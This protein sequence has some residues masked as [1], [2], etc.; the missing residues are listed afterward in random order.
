M[1]F[2][3]QMLSVIKLGFKMVFQLCAHFITALLNA[4][5]DDR[6]DVL[7]QRAIFMAHSSQTLFH[8]T[9]YGA[10]PPGMKGTHRFVSR[11]HQQDRETIS[12]LYAQGHARHIGD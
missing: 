3:E 4:W 8:N 11:I 10:P 9:A 6:V 7:R 5:A 1:D 2:V 12:S